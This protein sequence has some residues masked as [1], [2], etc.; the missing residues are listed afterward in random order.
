MLSYT[1]IDCL[2]VHD[3][4]LPQRQRKPAIK[5]ILLILREGIEQKFP[6]QMETENER[7]LRK[8]LEHKLQ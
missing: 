1:C 6:V 8:D 7:S 4:S 3:L 2:S 5:R